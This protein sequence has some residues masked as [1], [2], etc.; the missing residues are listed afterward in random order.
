MHVGEVNEEESAMGLA[1][2]ELGGHRRSTSGGH[3]EEARGLANLVGGG[4]TERRAI[5]EEVWGSTVRAGARSATWWWLG[6]EIGRGG[7]KLTNRSYVSVAYS[8]IFR[9]NIKRFDP[10]SHQPYRIISLHLVS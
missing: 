4:G 10:I 1:T 3:A 7:K 6:K 5:E 9:S 8:Y 2:H